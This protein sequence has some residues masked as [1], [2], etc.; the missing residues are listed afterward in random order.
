M[1]TLI[2]MLVVTLILIVPS[3]AQEMDQI[4]VEGFVSKPEYKK[5]WKS[6][7]H[8]LQTF[9]KDHVPQARSVFYPFGGPDLLHPLLLFPDAESYVLV[10]LETIGEPLTEKNSKAAYEKINSLLKRGFFVTAK[11]STSLNDKCGVRAA[12]AMEILLIGGKIKSD[13]LIDEKT[14]CIT[15]DLDGRERKVYY[16]RRNLVTSADSVF[17]FL[18]EKG[19]ND[20]CMM[21][22]ASYCPHREMFNAVTN[23]IV[24]NF[25]TILQD[26]TGIPYK[27]LKGF[28]LHL[29]GKYVKPYG[30]EW[31]GYE[32]PKLQKLFEKSQ[33]VPHLNF[34][35]GYGC[36]RVEANVVIATRKKE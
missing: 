10:G 15:F 3:I 17:S 36:G 29:Y 24:E 7:G 23:Y 12:L 6:F 26:D 33:D 2:R 4:N 22:A 8:K 20:A 25:N 34:C 16:L 18:A 27:D 9:Q 32:Q 19:I 30:V 21:K 5:F 13:E 35:Y 11:M 1:N 31:R 28:D 14:M